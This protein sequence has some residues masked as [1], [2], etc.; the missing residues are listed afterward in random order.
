MNTPWSREWRGGRSGITQTPDPTQG[1]EEEQYC[2]VQW[3]R[4]RSTSRR[5]TTT[6]RRP[7]KKFLQPYTTGADRRS[8]LSRRSTT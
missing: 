6:R 5:S 4:R 8:R 2:R 7:F 3:I 1:Q